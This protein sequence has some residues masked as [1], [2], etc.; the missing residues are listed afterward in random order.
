VRRGAQDGGIGGFDS[1]SARAE[2]ISYTA[3]R[4]QRC[5][6][7]LFDGP[8]PVH[9]RACTLAGRLAAPEH[10]VRDVEGR[11]HRQTQR[12]V[13]RPAFRGRLHLLVDIRCQLRDVRGIQRAADWIPLALDEDRNDAF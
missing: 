6:E 7:H 11:Q 9:N 10:L 2:E 4:M 8:G 5:V 12:V 13:R 1:M 3:L